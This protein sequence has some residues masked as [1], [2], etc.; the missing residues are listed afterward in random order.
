MESDGLLTRHG[1]SKYAE[2][3]SNI[4]LEL[5]WLPINLLDIANFLI[6]PNVIINYFMLYRM[7][8]T[9]IANSSLL[10]RLKIANGE[11]MKVVVPAEKTNDNTT[12]HEMRS[13]RS[14]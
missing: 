2:K 7:L 11:E 13:H 4:D 8:K 5:S 10:K 12:A 14:R 6:V 1:V 3:P 9:G